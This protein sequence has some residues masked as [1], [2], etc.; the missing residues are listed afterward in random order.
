MQ[1]QP[2]FEANF[3]PQHLNTACPL[4][5]TF[6]TNKF[7]TKEQMHYHDCLEI[8]LCLEGR[9]V[10]FINGDT[11]AFQKGDISYIHPGEPHIAQSPDEYP[12]K[13]WF[14]SVDPAL[15]NLVPARTGSTL[16]FDQKCQTL[17]ELGIQEL[18]ER[19]ENFE[20]AF[21]LL[22][23]IFFLQLDRLVTGKRAHRPEAEI[24]IIASALNYITLN[25][26]EDIEIPKLA[27]L[28]HLSASYFRRVFKRVTGKT[29]LHYLNEVRL[30]MAQSLLKTSDAKISGIA[31]QAGF[32]TLSSF[33]RQ[34]KRAFGKS[35]R[36]L[37]TQN[38]ERNG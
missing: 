38:T 4:R 30:S 34:F 9:G 16:F 36:E 25:Y 20:E 13:W 17:L 31:S 26:S 5:E 12:S 6:F 18:R 23:R 1:K 19:G 33:N 27:E 37:R 24:G 2:N 10:F 35:P 8:G 29:P 3:A 22:L 11:F 28:C 32:S 7:F 15:L 14:L 21:A